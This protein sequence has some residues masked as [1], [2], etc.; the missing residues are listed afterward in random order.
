MVKNNPRQA[1]LVSARGTISLLGRKMEKENIS[2][3]DMHSYV[4]TDPMHYMISLPK[5]SITS[6]LIQNSK[7]FC[8][9]FLSENQREQVLAIASVTGENKDKFIL[10]NFQKD[11]CEK[12]DAPRIKDSL[13]FLECSVVHQFDLE[14]NV[15][16]IGSVQHSLS[17]PGKRLYHI[18]GDQFTTTL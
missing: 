18:Q 16:F 9:N 1:I 8:V 17:L 15:I 5:S 10:G 13:G 7:H 6:Q 4:N 3:V 14:N 12:I 2:V 11:E